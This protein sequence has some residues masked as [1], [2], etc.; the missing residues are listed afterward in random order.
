[1]LAACA[2]NPGAAIV[3]SGMSGMAPWL[4]SRCKP[5]PIP[6]TMID[7]KADPL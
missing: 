4:H 2:A 6:S 5:Y 7:S 1:M 3:I